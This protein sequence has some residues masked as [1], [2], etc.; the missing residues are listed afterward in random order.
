MLPGLPP[1]DNASD[2]ELEDIVA[3]LPNP[4]GQGTLYYFLLIVPCIDSCQVTSYSVFE[5]IGVFS[6]V[7]FNKFRI[8]AFLFA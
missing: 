7:F 3:K 5:R 8:I 1:L 4:T 2:V 6:L